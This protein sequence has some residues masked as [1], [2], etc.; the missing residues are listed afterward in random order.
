MAH[1]SNKKEVS[2]QQKMLN[3]AIKGQLWR[4]GVGS[5]VTAPICSDTNLKTK[6]H[7]KSTTAL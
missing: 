6:K 2:Q 5:P 3:T 7:G 1:Y 4:M